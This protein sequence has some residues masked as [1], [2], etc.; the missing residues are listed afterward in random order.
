MAAHGLEKAACKN[1]INK[2]WNIFHI[3]DYIHHIVLTDF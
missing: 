2:T 3:S 1:L